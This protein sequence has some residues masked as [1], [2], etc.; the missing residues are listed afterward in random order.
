MV[1]R[2]LERNYAYGSHKK[3]AKKRI[4]DDKTSL[5]GLVRINAEIKKLTSIKNSR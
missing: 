2:F 1:E 4:V 5:R 3:R